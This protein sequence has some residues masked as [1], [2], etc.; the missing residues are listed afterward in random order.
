MVKGNERR[1]ILR[2]EAIYEFVV[3][4]KPSFVH[5]PTHLSF[6]SCIHNIYLIF[7]TIT[8]NIYHYLYTVLI[9]NVH[10]PGMILDHA[11]E[12]L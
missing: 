3:V 6:C 10:I 11:K 4:F 9:D 2:D 12:N 5:S 7:Q 1:D 8:I